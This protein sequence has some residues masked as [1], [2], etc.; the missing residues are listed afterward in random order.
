[1]PATTTPLPLVA[2][3]QPEP[4]QPYSAPP[5]IRFRDM[6]PATVPCGNYGLVFRSQILAGSDGAWHSYHAYLPPCYGDGRVY[7]V[8]YLIHGSVQTDTHWLD[9]GMRRL[10]DDGIREGRLPAMIIIMPYSGELGNITSGGS[11]SVEG[12]IVND[13]VPYVDRNFCAWQTRQ[14]R[15]IGGISRGGYW[16]LEIAFRN[17]WLF[18]GVAGHSSHLRFETDSATYNP[19]ATY[20]TNNLSGLRIWLDT[21]DED[22]LLDGQL[23]LHENLLNAGI[24]HQWHLNPG[25][26]YDGYWASHLWEYIGWHTWGWSRDRTAYPS[27]G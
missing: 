11:Y 26:H 21:G 10:M 9:L 7:P 16:A 6:P 27:C 2:N 18:G 4:S 1:M 19:L 15:S 3:N 20:A 8:I 17:T 22:F 24:Q 12:V 14:G 25:T 23:K 13:V 5:A